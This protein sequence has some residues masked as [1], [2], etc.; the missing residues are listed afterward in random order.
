M[1]ATDDDDVREVF[2]PDHSGQ[3]QVPDESILG[4]SPAYWSHVP[5]TINQVQDLRLL[6]GIHCLVRKNDQ[7][8]KS[9]VVPLSKC[10]LVGVVVAVEPRGLDGGVVYVIDDGTGLMDCLYWHNNDDAGLPSLTLRE[11]ESTIL[12]VGTFARIFGRIEC[13][14]IGV[15]STT[16]K[17]CIRE[18]HAT[19]VIEIRKTEWEPYIGGE[20]FESQHWKRCI[21][22]ISAE[23]LLPPETI[24]NLL[25]TDI[26]RQIADRASLPAVDDTDG[27]WRVFGSG[28]SCNLLYKHHLL[29]CHC[30]ATEEVLDPQLRYRD[31]LLS[32]LIELERKQPNR[33]PLRFQFRTVKEIASLKELAKSITSAPSFQQ[34]LLQ[35]TFRALR[36]D[37]ILYLLDAESDTYLL[38]SKERV[39]ERYVDAMTSDDIARGAQRAQLRREPPAFLKHVPKQRLQ[40]VRRNIKRTSSVS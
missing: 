31:S 7:T 32:A 21:K 26:A 14:A 19:V 13:A 17:N 25:G 40:Y 18:V 12:A 38:V 34:S 27:S 2:P 15:P 10:E 23:M 11:P 33:L 6:N 20:D 16:T 1:T 35:G 29:Y 4:L 39:L 5:L 24:V 22:G 8:G 37:G 3:P 9:D 28:C 36:N 30:Q